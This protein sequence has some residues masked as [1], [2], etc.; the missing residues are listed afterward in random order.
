MLP[1]QAHGGEFT[2]LI[3]RPRIFGNSINRLAFVMDENRVYCAVGT[4][5]IAIKWTN[6]MLNNGPIIRRNSC[7]YGTLGTC[8]SVWMTFWYAGWNEWWWAHSRPKHVEIDKCTKNKLCTRL[9]LFTRLYRDAR[10]T[11]HKKYMASWKPK[12][13]AAMLF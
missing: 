2:N 12:H 4:E 7:V 5:C 3:V 8:Y 6:C 10:S 13:V 11:K 1:R 9:V